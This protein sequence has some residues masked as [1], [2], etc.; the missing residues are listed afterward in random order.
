[1]LTSLLIVATLVMQTG[2]PG[3]QTAAPSITLDFLATGSD[4]KTVPD[5]TAADVT[6]KVDGK[7][8][9]LTSLELRS[10]ADVGRNILLLV[11]EATL[12]GLEP[13]L[14][15]AVGK[16]LASLQPGDKIAYVSTRRGRITA[17]S[18]QHAT[19]TKT[20]PRGR[21]TT[22][23]VLSRGSSFDPTFGTDQAG[24]GCTPRIED[25]RRLS[26]VISAAQIN[27]HFL[28]VDHVNRSWG[29]DTLASNTGSGTGLLTWSDAGALERAVAGT[30]SYY[31]ATFAADT[32]ANDR[33]QRV[34]LRVERPGATVKTSPTIR[35]KAGGLSR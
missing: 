3:S 35:L 30:S 20:L 8:R 12:Y 17:L 22:V 14:K 15:D 18:T 32:R 4:G 2:G 21:W 29:L 26:E 34:E 9:P 19:V 24:G 33:P 27:V 23:A 6:L 7:V 31:R 1:M 25:L 28:T 13:V 11:D 16:L 5:L 10:T